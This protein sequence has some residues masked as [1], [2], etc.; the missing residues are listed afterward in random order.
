MTSLPLTPMDE[1]LCLAATESYEAA[2]MDAPA[3]IDIAFF[4]RQLHQNTS[5]EGSINFP[6]WPD[7]QFVM[8]RL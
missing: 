3:E 2:F 7:Y 6:Q 5:A 1:L 4:H 8:H